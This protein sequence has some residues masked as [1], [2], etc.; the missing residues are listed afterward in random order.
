[1]KDPVDCALIG[2]GARARKLYLPLA[3]AVAPWLR[4]RA[5]CSASAGSAGVAASALGVPAFTSVAELVSARL[6]EAAV[7][8]SPIE[9]HHALSLYLSGHGI[10]HLVETSMCSLLGQAHQMVDS[11]R[12]AGVTMTVAENTFR[13]PF[14]RLAGLVVHSGAIGEVRRLSCFHDN[15]GFHGHARW[16]K[17]F[18]AYPTSVQSLEHAMPTARHVESAHRVHNG[19]TFRACFAH[20]PGGRLALDMGGNLKGMLGRQPRP[21]LTE[22]DGTRGAIARMAGD[23]LGGAAEVRICSEKALGGGGRADT[24]VPFVDVV[25]DGCW[26]SSWVDLPCGRV[27]WVNEHRPGRVSGPKLRE[28]DAAVVMEILVR[29]AEQV[30][31][32]RPPEFAAEDGLRTT[33]VEAASR[34]S[35]LRD[36]ARIGLPVAPADLEGEQAVAAA[37]RARFGVDP[38]DVEAMMAVHFPPAA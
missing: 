12:S 25:S 33:E 30:R 8:L 1:M 27:E 17:L 7:V 22:I 5:V 35:A 20:F 23:A 24:V 26:T 28:W 3:A 36:G 11:A 18:D 10:H 9:S 37:L 2:I 14:D 6:V 34:E 29:F 4:I 31:G 16:I 21:G 13:F 19:E 38:M 15:V 32:R